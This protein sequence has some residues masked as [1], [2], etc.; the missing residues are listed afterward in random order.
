MKEVFPTSDIKQERE[1]L[2]PWPYPQESIIE[3]PEIKLGAV[4]EAE[5]T[6]KV[7]NLFTQYG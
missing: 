6:L 2:A 7:N 4:P 1:H 5:S 3:K